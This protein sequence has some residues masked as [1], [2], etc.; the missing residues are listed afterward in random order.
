MHPFNFDEMEF[1]FI[2]HYLNA[3]FLAVIQFSE[4]V[5]LVARVYIY[6]CLLNLTNLVLLLLYFALILILM[7]A[8]LEGVD[9][10]VSINDKDFAVHVLFFRRMFLRR[11]RMSLSYFSS[12]AKSY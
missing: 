11:S 2:P 6:F 1:A 3:T 5:Y 9:H 7:M 12:F 8:V 4:F 10:F